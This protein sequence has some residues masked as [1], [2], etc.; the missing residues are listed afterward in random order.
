VSANVAA[1]GGLKASQ[2]QQCTVCYL[3]VAHADVLFYSVTV[4]TYALTKEAFR[5]KE[6]GR[7]DTTRDPVLALKQGSKTKFYCKQCWIEAQDQGPPETV[8]VIE[9][10]TKSSLILP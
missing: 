9:P 1:T 5:T 8:E 4:S 7:E 6:P 3:G 10:P 2:I